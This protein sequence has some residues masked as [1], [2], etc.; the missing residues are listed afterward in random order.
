MGRFFE[1]TPQ[2]KY[3]IMRPDGAIL[4]SVKDVRALEWTIQA[5][6]DNTDALAVLYQNPYQIP[7]SIAAQIG[8]QDMV[9]RALTQTDEYKLDF[10][11]TLDAECIGYFEQFQTK[12]AGQMES[13]RID[14]MHKDR[15]WQNR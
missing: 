10:E 5:N 7:R 1:G 8:A 13:F 2:Y 12:S 4:T 6:M 11:R 14:R 15:I 9:F 3:F